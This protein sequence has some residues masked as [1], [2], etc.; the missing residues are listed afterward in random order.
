MHEIWKGK[1][2]VLFMKYNVCSEVCQK[3]SI[4]IINYT[5]KTCY[6]FICFVT[7][8]DMRPLIA[9]GWSWNGTTSFFLCRALGLFLH[10]P[11]L[12]ALMYLEPLLKFSSW[13]IQSFASII[14]SRTKI[15]HYKEQFPSTLTLLTIL[16]RACPYEMQ[17]GHLMHN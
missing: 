10:M 13:T 3:K 5:K 8:R 16:V 14:F 6:R 15:A 12:L 11:L 2:V 1:S 4:F 17:Q 7:N 9:S